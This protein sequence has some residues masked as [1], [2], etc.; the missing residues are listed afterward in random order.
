MNRHLWGYLLAALLA[1][2]GLAVAWR[3]SAERDQALARVAELEKRISLPAAPSSSAAPPASSPENP[4]PG[5]PAK[6]SLPPANQPADSHVITD[7]RAR[8]QDLEESL[9][10]AAAEKDQ[11]LAQAADQAAAS[12][13]LQSELDSLKD[14]L[15][16]A[17][18][19]TSALDADLKSKS[20]RL[21]A[22]DSA[23]RALQDRLSKAE[24]QAR[25]L[26]RANTE[27]DD[28]NRRRETSLASL[29][30]RYR[31]VTDLLRNF[32]LNAQ[33]RESANPGLQAGDLSRIQ[34][35]LQQAE[36]ELRQLRALN[37]RAAALA[38]AK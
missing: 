29:Q 10:K 7:L 13:R 14:S 25:T 5:S 24:A 17:Q 28:L 18:R 8:L 38:R 2:L 15:E 23:Q 31:E 16:S 36:D 4:K 33:N 21:A 30:Q 9:R 35:T 19:Q 27:L 22:L 6:P 11:A 1:I 3:A 37:A 32:S 34:S 20:D 12:K 26:T